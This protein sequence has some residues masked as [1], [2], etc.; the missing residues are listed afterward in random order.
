VEV[1]LDYITD[2]QADEWLNEI[3]AAVRCRRDT[4]RKRRESNLRMTLVVGDVVMLREASPKYL[5]DLRATVEAVKRTRVHVRI[6]A[7]DCHKARHFAD[8]R[9]GVPL[10]CVRLL[11]EPEMAA[12]SILPWGGEGGCAPVNNAAS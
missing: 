6:I 7:Q 4:L 9:V 1:L 5:N 3:V 8:S 2:G 10:S 11:N 12:L